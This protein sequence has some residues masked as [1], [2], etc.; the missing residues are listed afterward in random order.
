MAGLRRSKKCQSPV[1]DGRRCADS[2]AVPDG[3]PNLRARPT[4]GLKPWAIF[5]K[6]NGIP[7]FSPRLYAGRYVISAGGGTGKLPPRRGWLPL[8]GAST[9]MPRRRRWGIAP[10]SVSDLSNTAVE[11]A[12]CIL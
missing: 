1:R 4:P 2:S 11:T 9:K 8:A 10:G 3:T 5:R 12:Y 7:T 6:P